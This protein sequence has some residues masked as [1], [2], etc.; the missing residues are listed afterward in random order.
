MLPF[1]LIGEKLT[2]PDSILHCAMRAPW[3]L[4]YAGG[5]VGGADA[6]LAVW[7]ENNAYDPHRGDLMWGVW[8]FN[9]TG[10]LILPT[11]T[12]PLNLSVVEATEYVQDI[13]RDEI[14]H[15]PAGVA[16]HLQHGFTVDDQ[17]T[18][19]RVSFVEPTSGWLFEW[20]NCQSGEVVTG[21]YSTQNQNVQDNT[22]Q[23]AGAQNALNAQN[24]GVALIVNSAVA[25]SYI[26]RARVAA[27]RPAWSGLPIDYA[28][29]SGNNQT[30]SQF[31]WRGL[32]GIV[33]YYDPIWNVGALPFDP[34]HPLRLAHNAAVLAG[35]TRKNPDWT[36]QVIAIDASGLPAPRSGEWSAL[37]VV[38]G[39][40]TDGAGNWIGD[41]N[42]H[43]NA[44]FPAFWKIGTG[45]LSEVVVD[46]RLRA[47]GAIENHQGSLWLG[48]MLAG[49][50]GPQPF[51][52][53]YDNPNQAP[54][55]TTTPV[56]LWSKKC[57]C[58]LLTSRMV[59]SLSWPNGVL[60]ATTPCDSIIYDAVHDVLIDAHPGG[61]CG[62]A[63]RVGAN[64]DL[65]V[66][67]CEG[68]DFASNAKFPY[69]P[70]TIVT[71]EPGQEAAYRGAAHHVLAA[72]AVKSIY[73]YYIED[74]GLKPVASS[75]QQSSTQSQPDPT[76]TPTTP[77]A[78]Y[79]SIC[80]FNGQ[81]C[82]IL[83]RWDTSRFDLA[84]IGIAGQ[85]VFAFGHTLD[86]KPAVARLDTSG[87]DPLFRTFA[88]NLHPR[89]IATTI[90][91]DGTRETLMMVAKDVDENGLPTDG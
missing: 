70:A 28:A 57:E 3:G 30:P 8:G 88:T 54:F 58:N 40:G 76:T 45:G 69:S 62:A 36:S 29:V 80:R 15:V 82:D 38:V 11:I 32:T 5:Q 19:G 9:G 6:D 60:H 47:V 75:T 51:V 74:E 7:N 13:G 26:L 21:N 79:Q 63:L 71:G 84:H 42:C 91:D 48:G 49:R 41:V 31:Q 72:L 12:T 22:A 83:A 10:Y 78:R 33:Y 4:V 14:A 23:N 59:N 73:G 50:S 46:P 68:G 81:S 43:P 52:V 17:R 1:Q 64:R 34:T 77:A 56:P 25:G 35:T 27:Q 66:K 86:L 61:R 67:T 87:V 90:S 16:L 18:D 39:T 2:L 55:S 53:R 24:N 85:Y 20:I 65:W 89:N 37:K 44:A